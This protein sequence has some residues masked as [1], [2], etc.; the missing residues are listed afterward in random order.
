[1]I[2][3]YRVLFGTIHLSSDYSNSIST[4]FYVEGN[5]LFEYNSTKNYSY[6]ML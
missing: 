1:M 2:Y 6:T 5:N 4:D 3:S